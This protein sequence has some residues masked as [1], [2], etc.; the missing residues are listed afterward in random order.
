[1]ETDVADKIRRYGA[2]K[3]IISY[4]SLT[5]TPPDLEETF[6]RMLAQ[7]GDVYKVAVTAQTPADVERVLKLQR[8]APK[9]TVAFCMGE[10]GLPSQFLSLKFGAPWIYAA[11][12]KKRGI[13]PGLPSLED[14]KTTYPVRPVGPETRI[15]G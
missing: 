11:F 9:P 4:H 14:F 2:T 15:Y 1:L 8:T 12:N 13:A 5:G 3:R 10:L 7:D 6:E